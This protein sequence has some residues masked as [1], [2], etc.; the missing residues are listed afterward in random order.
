MSEQEFSSQDSIIKHPSVSLAK[1]WIVLDLGCGLGRTAP[2]VA[3]KVRQYVGV[4]FSKTMIRKAQKRNRA[5]SNVVFYV[6]NGWGLPM[7]PTNFIDFAFCELLFQHIVKENTLSYI[8]DV[9]RVLKVG[10]VFL[11]QIP[12]LDFYGNEGGYAFSKEEIDYYFSGGWSKYSSFEYLKYE[13]EY[14]YYLMRAVK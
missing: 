14:A 13:H 3:P 9:Y 8:R 2:L 1:D 7:F 5:F 10:G 4:D 12:K 11:A 6:N